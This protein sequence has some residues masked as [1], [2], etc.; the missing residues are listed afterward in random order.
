MKS[1]RADE[2]HA[3]D[4]EDYLAKQKGLRHLRIRRRADT[5]TLQSGPTDD[6]CPHARFRRV[7]V[8]LWVLEMPNHTGRWEP[9]P[10]RDTLENLAKT[11][12]KS[13]PWAV[14]PVEG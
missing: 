11:L 12:V 9:T 7:S 8:H 4:L 2:D 14:A 13:F 3:E 1:L 10:Y 5:L 6:P